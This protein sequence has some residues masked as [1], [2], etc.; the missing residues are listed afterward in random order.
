MGTEQL[1]KFNKI[2]YSDALIDR[3]EALVSLYEQG[4]VLADNLF[5]L[6]EADKLYFYIIE[7]YIPDTV[8]M[9]NNK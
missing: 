7:A 2:P 6:D 9:E 5:I 1:V 8:H 3:F 4:V